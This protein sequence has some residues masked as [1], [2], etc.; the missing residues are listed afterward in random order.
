MLGVEVFA[1]PNQPL[2]AH[3]TKCCTCASEII[4]NTK[5]ALEARSYAGRRI[6][7]QECA[8][9]VCNRGVQQGWGRTLGRWLRAPTSNSMSI[10]VKVG[11]KPNN[12][13]D[14]CRGGGGVGWH[15]LCRHA[16]AQRL[17]CVA[18]ELNYSVDAGAA[19]VHDGVE[20][21]ALGGAV[22]AVHEDEAAV[23]ILEPGA[24][25]YENAAGGVCGMLEKCSAGGAC[26]VR[27]TR[28]ARSRDAR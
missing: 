18:H 2:W 16:L 28:C 17:V 20:G 22:G 11:M 6:V 24:G 1:H 10:T 12:D 23:A 21:G 7:Q 14:R 9:G 26:G 3:Q 13:T 5:A 4:Y 25:C 8:T 27:R 15:Q 19:G